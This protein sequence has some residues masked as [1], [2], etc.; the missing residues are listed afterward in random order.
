MSASTIE[1]D[2]AS[3]GFA[4]WTYGRTDVGGDDERGRIYPAIVIIE[5][6][7]LD[8]SFYVDGEAGWL[9]NDPTCRECGVAER[10][11]AQIGVQRV[12]RDW[13]PIVGDVWDISD[14]MSKRESYLARIRHP[15]W[16]AIETGAITLT[17]AFDRVRRLMAEA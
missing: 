16:V 4:V 13:P 10:M 8:T 6:A 15:E 14:S 17:Q 7:D 2:R 9:C 1:R 3:L 11:A 12:T 5:P